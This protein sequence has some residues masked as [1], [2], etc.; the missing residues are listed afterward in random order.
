MALLS[1][2]ALA[3]IDQPELLDQGIGSR[4]DV[5]ANLTEM[6]RSNR[7]LGGMAALTRHLYPR[8]RALAGPVRLLDLGSGSAQ[9]PLAL[10]RW[11]RQNEIHAEVIAADWSARNLSVAQALHADSPGVWLI[12][13]DAAH[14]PFAPASVDYVISTLFLHHFAPDSLIALLRAASICARRGLIMSD[15]VRGRLPLAAFR[16]AQPLIARHYLTRHD[17]ALSIRRAYTP[18]ELRD[19]AHA[20][21]LAGAQVIT[22]WPWRMTLVVDRS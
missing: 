22:H 3:R 14:P 17:G 15:L 9:I 2:L 10:A 20:A 21:G 16:L 19:L 8:L 18:G 12:Q 1:S 5:Q 6:W 11:A 4:A 13:A 7:Y